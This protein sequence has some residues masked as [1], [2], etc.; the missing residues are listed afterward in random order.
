MI[1]LNIPPEEKMEKDKYKSVENNKNNSNEKTNSG[2]PGKNNNQDNN[3]KSSKKEEVKETVKP[4]KQTKEKVEPAFSWFRL[5]A[6]SL[7]T[8]TIAVIIYMFTMAFIRDNPSLIT[9]EPKK[10]LI[11]I[12]QVLRNPGNVAFKEKD[13]LIVLVVGLDENRDEYGIA[14]TKGSRTDTIFLIKVDK[15]AE[16]LGILSIPRD[17]WVLISEEKGYDKINSAFPIAFWEVFGRTN[18]YEQGIMAGLMQTRRTVQDFLGIHVD[19]VVLLKLDAC[20]QIIDSIG[21]VTI[22]VEKDMV[23]DDYWGNLHIDLKQG[24]HRLNGEQAVGYARFRH[25][26]EADWGRMRRQQQVIQALVNE[27]KK[28]ANILRINKLAS[29]VKSNLT[30]DFSVLELID[31]AHVYKNFNQNNIFKGVITGDD[32]WAGGGMIVI[33]NETEKKRLVRRILLSPDEVLPE[34]LRIRVVNGTTVENV[35]WQMVKHLQDQGFTVVDVVEDPGGKKFNT[36]TIVFHHHQ[37]YNGAMMI[38]KLI[39]CRTTVRYESGEFIDDDYDYIVIVG[40]SFLFSKAY[41]PGA[42]MTPA[43]MPSFGI[44]EEQNDTLLTPSPEIIQAEPID[45]ETGYY[46]DIDDETIKP[47][48]LMTPEIFDYKD[49]EKSN[50]SGVKFITPGEIPTGTDTKTNSEEQF[51]VK[52]IR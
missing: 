49:L 8:I 23:Y 10:D 4:E 27:L 1:F 9:F 21:G 37:N 22:D 12:D 43:P 6:I 38:E 40:D 20:K 32:D 48:V 34:D 28:P 16:R 36:T 52:I 14:H 19:Y 7:L 30:T 45:P 13:S 39:Q 44:D 26:E 2:N 15:K 51:D 3:N 33:P 17:T 25:D 50:E 31:I 18:D 41:T 42:I 24:P 5:F 29:I 11:I 35:G 47:D 46:P